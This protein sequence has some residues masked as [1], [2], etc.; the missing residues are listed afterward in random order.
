MEGAARSLRQQLSQASLYWFEHGT[1]RRLSLILGVHHD[2]RTAVAVAPH[3]VYQS[4]VEH[5]IGC[6]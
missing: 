4:V 5:L 3:V 1:R 6:R 2:S